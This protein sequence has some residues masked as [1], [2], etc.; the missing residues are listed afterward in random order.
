MKMPTIKIPRTLMFRLHWRIGLFSAFF[1]LW[2]AITGILL[3][4]SRMLG[5]HHV[6]LDHP[7]ILSAYN[8]NVSEELRGPGINLERLILDL[9]TGNLFGISGKLLSDLAAIAMIFVTLSGIYN[10]WRRKKGKRKKE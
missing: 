7:I 6:I 9:H 1:I 10:L 4:H 5:F 3:N 8:M 2:L